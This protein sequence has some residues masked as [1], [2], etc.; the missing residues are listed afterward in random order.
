MLIFSL[1]EQ[2]SKSLLLNSQT[3]SLWSH[4]SIILPSIKIDAIQLLTIFEL[5]SVLRTMT[6]IFLSI[7][8]S[9]GRQLINY[10]IKFLCFRSAWFQDARTI[11]WCHP[12]CTCSNSNQKRRLWLSGRRNSLRHFGVEQSPTFGKCRMISQIQRNSHIELIWSGKPKIYL[13]AISVLQITGICTGPGRLN[14]SSL[15]TPLLIWS[16]RNC[17]VLPHSIA[18]RSWLILMELLILPAFQI[19]YRWALLS[20]RPTL[21]MISAPSLWIR[22]STTSLWIWISQT[23]SRK[24][25]GQNAMIVSSNK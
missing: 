10:S 25:T 17:L 19:Y 6:N 4:Y 7:R 3:C 21:S 16:F 1:I 20:S 22:G 5:A 14:V 15:P 24:S 18:I 8:I 2:F 23:S 12:T 11:S 13:S 9:E